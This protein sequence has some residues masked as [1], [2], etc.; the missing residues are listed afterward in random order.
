MRFQNGEE[1]LLTFPGRFAVAA[2][3]HRT[4]GT[5]AGTGMRPFLLRKNQGTDNQ[6]YKKSQN[7]TDQKG[8]P[9]CLEP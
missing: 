6:K 8:S 9:I 3:F 1:V 4:A 2:V 5:T 7:D